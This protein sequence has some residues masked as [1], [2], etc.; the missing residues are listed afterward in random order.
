MPSP[1]RLRHNA[2]RFFGWLQHVAASPA[3]LQRLT[4]VGAGLIM[5]PTLIGFALIVWLGYSRTP[6]L[7]SQSL[8]WMGMALLASM[9]LWGLVVIAL[10]NVIKGVRV[11]G[12]GGFNVNFQTTADDP[13]VDPGTPRDGDDDHQHGGGFG[14]RHDRRGGR[15]M[16]AITD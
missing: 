12:P 15:S 10:L 11:A 3:G 7:Q 16:P 5:W 1:L 2:S 13:D 6:E 9:V 8:D 4:V 14:G